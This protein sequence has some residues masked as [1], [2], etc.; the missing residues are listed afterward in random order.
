M[1]GEAEESGQH[2]KDCEAADLPVA[3]FFCV[4]R[5]AAGAVTD[6]GMWRRVLREWRGRVVGT[7]WQSHRGAISQVLEQVEAVEAGEE[8][9]ASQKQVKGTG[10]DDKCE[11]S[12]FRVIAD[13]AG[14]GQLVR[15]HRSHDEDGQC[16]DRG[17]EPRDEMQVRGFALNR[18]RWP[19]KSGRQEP[20]DGQI[21]PPQCR[22]HA[23]EVDDDKDDGAAEVVRSFCDQQADVVLWLLM[24]GDR[25]PAKDQ[26]DEVAQW[27]HEVRERHDDDDALR[28]T[29]VWGVRQEGADGESGRQQ[30]DDGPDQEP[31]FGK[32][33]VFARKQDVR[34]APVAACFRAIDVIVFGRV[35][36]RGTHGGELCRGRG[37]PAA[38][39]DNISDRSSW[40]VRRPE[41]RIGEGDGWN[42]RTRRRFQPFART[43]HAHAEA[44]VVDGKVVAVQWCGPRKA[45][46]HEDRVAALLHALAQRAAG[47]DVL[48]HFLRAHGHIH[49]AE[50]K[51]QLRRAAVLDQRRERLNE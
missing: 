38:G 23:E 50:E 9:E 22:R 21:D 7:M 42:W 37:D 19:V 11:Q 49:G 51:A 32:V 44:V 33:F 18:F 43:L 28:V 48:D 24:T 17:N 1:K 39:H 27:T 16:L 13:E 8:E 29:E 14:A 3:Q 25:L 26:A 41:S 15:V 2:V 12:A 46:F 4:L 35:T 47:A 20:R 6:V 34:L 31:R 5:I 36:I 45:E 10:D 40:V 30:T